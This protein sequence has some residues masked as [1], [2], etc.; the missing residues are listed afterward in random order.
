MGG[1]DVPEILI[2]LLLVGFIGLAVHHYRYS[3]RH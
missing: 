2:V 1:F 3:H